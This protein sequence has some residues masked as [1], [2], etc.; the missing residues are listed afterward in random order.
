MN[1]LIEFE[2]ELGLIQEHH[3]LLHLGQQ[4]GLLSDIRFW[5]EVG[6]TLRLKVRFFVMWLGLGSWVTILRL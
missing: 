3:Q 4:L 5:I 1:R 6:R 2:D